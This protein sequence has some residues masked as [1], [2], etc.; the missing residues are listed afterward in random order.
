MSQELIAI[1]SVGAGL[2]T[3][4]LVIFGWL[5]YSIHQ[6]EQRTERRMDALEARTKENMDALEARTKENMDA[7]E[8]RLGDRMRET[9]KRMDAQDARVQAV[10]AHLH[11]IDK[12]LAHVAGLLDG[13]R[14]AI[15]HRSASSE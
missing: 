6:A 14:E 3:L 5:L 12:Q 4:N 9:E 10:E 1:L 8:A 11:S 13:L 2:G 15:F 7:L